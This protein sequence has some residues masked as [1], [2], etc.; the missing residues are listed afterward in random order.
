[1]VSEYP[2]G[3]P[4][5]KPCWTL[6]MCDTVTVECEEES[7]C[8][9]FNSMSFYWDKMQKTMVDCGD[10]ARLACPPDDCFWTFSGNLICKNDC[11]ISSV[12]WEL[13][14]SDNGLVV[15]SGNTLSYPAFGILIP[16]GIV[17]AGGEYDLIFA[18]HCDDSEICVCSI[19][20]IF[21]GCNE[22]CPCDVSQFIDDVN[23]GLGQIIDIGQCR[24]CFVPAQLNACDR[25]VWN[26]LP[27]N[28]LIATSYGP[29]MICWDFQRS[30]NHQ[31]LMTVTRLNDDGSVCEVISKIVTITTQCFLPPSPQFEI[32][33]ISNYS[34]NFDQVNLTTENSWTNLLGK[35]IWIKNDVD[36]LTNVAL[37]KGNLDFSDK[38]ISYNPNCI[39][40]GEMLKLDS[41]F[42]LIQF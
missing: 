30:G 9:G 29:N 33:C 32:D 4:T 6:Q 13:V 34:N 39:K 35:P 28:R 25:V 20:L 23:A 14:N 41:K 3:D 21:S 15:A 5:Q 7:Q 17:T 18:G 42:L 12:S 19:H 2:N 24:A 8:E 36:Y 37:L 16:P 31:L 11:E 27:S 10:T 40:A 38:L 1:M 26:L 22:I